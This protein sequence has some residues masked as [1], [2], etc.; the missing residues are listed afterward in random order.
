M[1][2]LRVAELAQHLRERA[3]ETLDLAEWLSL[4]AM[5]FMGDF[6]FSGGLETMR[7][8]AD[9]SGIRHT[10]EEGLSI[11]EALGT[12]PW[13]RA[14][15]SLLPSKKAQDFYDLAISIAERRRAAGGTSKDL[16]YHLVSRRA[17]SL[18]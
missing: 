12:V 17:P 15:V 4:L 5:D 7:A 9:V 16:M 13:V 1:L 10:I 3:G 8:G 2:I 14:L 6:E 11:G 18:V